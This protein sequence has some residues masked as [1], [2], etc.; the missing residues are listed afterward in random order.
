MMIVLD[1]MNNV[2]KSTLVDWVE[3]HYGIPRF[4]HADVGDEEGFVLS[5]LERWAF[6]E[7]VAIFDRFFFT[8]LAYPVL[9]DWAHGERCPISEA[10]IQMAVKTLAEAKEQGK[11]LLIHA[12]RELDDIMAYEIRL[13]PAMRQPSVRE[14]LARLLAKFDELFQPWNPVIYNIDQPES[15]ARVREQV[16]EF[17]GATAARPG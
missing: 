7:D 13:N 1:G 6:S 11:L 12:R 9:G 3:E 16:A 17:V 5:H 15:I 10:C 14:N 4:H 8:Y 2:G